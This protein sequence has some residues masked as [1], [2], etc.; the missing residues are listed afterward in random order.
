[1]RKALLATTALF[2]LTA[3]AF[4]D[5]DATPETVVVT[6]TRTPQPIEKTGSSISVITAA[7]LKV[8]QT[9]VLTDI[10]AETPGLT[11]NRNGGVGQPT[12]ISLRGAET[13]QTV[14]LIDGVRINDPSATDEGAIL[15]DVLTNNI[16]R[17]EILRGP[18][19]TLY[20]SD[21]MGGVVNILS[22]RG[23]D[24]P[25]GGTASAE[26]GSFDTFHLNAAA[27]GTTDNVEYGA[28]LNWFD[29]GG[30]S[31][32]D[33]RNGNTEA[34][35]YENFGATF[36]TRTHLSQDWSID[37]RGYYTHGHDDFDD[38]F[39]PPNFQIA[40]SAANNTNELFAGYAGVNATF[41][42]LQNRL[43]FIATEGTRDYFDSASDTVHKNY[44]YEGSA[45]RLEYQGIVD[46][47][48][49]N[50]LTF[51]AETE[52]RS[53]RNDNFG[54]N[55][56]FSPPVQLGHDRISSGYA[57]MQT[58]LFDQLTLTGGVRYDDDEEFGG[59]TSLKLAGAWNIPGWDTTLRANYGDG[60]KAPSLYELYSQYANPFH[61]LKPETAKGWEAG[62][63]KSLLDGR[64]LG[65]L[66]YFERHT[67]NQIDFVD[68]FT[69]PYG[70]YENLDRTRATGTEA[71]ITAKLTDA[72]TVSADYT[73]L[74]AKNLI[75]GTE[76]ARRP[77]NSASG[78]I[79][80]LPMP[81]LTLGTS[82]I[83]VGDRF[84]D[85][86][87]FVPL[88]S[89]TTVNVFGS[90]AF[91]DKL[92]LFG[93]VENLFNE[94]SEDVAGYGRMGLAAYGGIRA[95]F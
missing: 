37:L 49:A 14:V 19:S 73:N 55:A 65:S 38:N 81:K 90:Y 39:P 9:D 31:A 28:A 72:L 16:D 26:G 33:S 41:G 92:E 27:N 30:I 17:V 78:T 82:V 12:S 93:R 4:A 68:T 46:I 34:D 91:T 22:K 7:D 10:L 58:T 40:D 18:Q 15:S 20:G 53:F 57:Q 95:A 29:T 89:N 67:H 76:L 51:G 62:V 88:Q 63:D 77:H 47:N 45:S 52:E 2:A 1:M 59:H 32:A 74:T 50:Q 64:L 24:T 21:A 25:F 69:P 36:N 11:V 54:I 66:T 35:G 3:P 84:D 94:K 60:F 8:Q 86:G 61:A 13:G 42:M 71:E 23:G 79:T 80:W 48:N 85:G 5:D 6:A 75:T 44:D 83:F 56:L 70:Y 87:N 43:A